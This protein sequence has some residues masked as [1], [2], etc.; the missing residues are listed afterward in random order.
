MGPQIEATHERH[1]A[2]F[3]AL[4]EA[5]FDYVWV[6]LRRLGVAE[7]DLEDVTQEMFLQVHNRFDDYDATRPARPWL[8]AFACRF[9]SDYRRLARHRVA[10]VGEPLEM[11]STG[12]D[13]E[14]AL[15]E[16]DARALVAEALDA[17][18]HD[19]RAVF[20]AHEIDESPVANIA[21]ILEVPLFTAYSRLR[22]ARAQFTSAVRRI[23]LRR[24]GR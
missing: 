16:K 18:D 11:P 3:R 17:L 6:S 8:Y 1:R 22:A 19:Q 2:S 9:A 21:E 15:A 5:E 4:L 12:P 10:L 20:V 13:A 7:R 14:D 24:G 23:V